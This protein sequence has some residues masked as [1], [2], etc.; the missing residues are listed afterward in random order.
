M[1]D[2]TFTV[3]RSRTIHAPAATVY[4]YIADLHAWRTWSPWE[5]LDENLKREY[6]GPRMGAGARYAWSGNRKAGEGE[7]IIT[8]AV[9]PTSLAMSL[10]FT[11]PMKSTNE[12]QFT[13]GEHGDTC[14]VTWT[15]TG[16]QTLFTRAA[17]LLG[18]MDKILGKQFNQG[19]E[20]LAAVAEP[21]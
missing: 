6:S 16:Q 12:L 21:D 4:P 1:A 11:K 15:M 3:E 8:E 14:T 17:S 10:A 2:K 20:R 5:N 18:G 13:L 9:E 7:M 19:L